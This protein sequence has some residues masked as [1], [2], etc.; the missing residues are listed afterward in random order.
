PISTSYRGHQ[1]YELPPNSQGFTLLQILNLIEPFDLQALGHGS[2]DYYHLLVEATKL[3]FADRDRWLGDPA[4]VEIPV[5]ELISKA[6]CDRRRARLSLTQAQAY[7][8]GSIGGDTVY[9]AV[10]DSYG[11]AVS[12]IQS[13][14]FDFG[15]AVVPPGSGF[16]LQNR[17]HCFRLDSTHPNGLAPGKR[18]FHTLMPG[19]VTDSDNRLQLVF[20]TMGG[21]GQPQ[22]QVALLTRTLDFGFDPQSAIDLPRWLWGRTWGEAS[23]HLNLEGRIDRAVGQALQARGHDVKFSPGWAEQMGHAH[24]IVVDVQTGTLRGGSDPRS[25]GAALGL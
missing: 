20:G 16:V 9:S 17:A 4:F 5:T 11:N 22:T 25:D 8:P 10:V 12:M 7:Q 3:A 23:T 14:Y 2:A 18:S 15:S 1:V 6:Y 21:E 19:L 13:L 24:M